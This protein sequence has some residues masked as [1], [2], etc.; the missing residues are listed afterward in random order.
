MAVSSMA[1][2][3]R[4]PAIEDELSVR[5]RADHVVHRCVD[6]PAVELAARLTRDRPGRG[7]IPDG[8]TVERG[9]P[10][11]RTG[12]R[13]RRRV[14]DIPEARDE[15]RVARGRHRDL[16]RDPDGRPA[17]GAG[18][19]GDRKGRRAD[20]LGVGE[21]HD[22]DPCRPAGR[23]MALGPPDERVATVGRRGGARVDELRLI[24][25]GQRGVALPVERPQRRWRERSPV[26]RGRI[27]RQLEPARA[28]AGP[29][30]ADARPAAARTGEDGGRT[31][32]RRD[33]HVPEGPVGQVD[34]AIAVSGMDHQP[35]RIR[36]R[37][38]DLEHRQA[39]R[40]RSRRGRRGRGRGRSGRRSHCR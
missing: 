11:V 33:R 37:S 28:R 3:V 23:A 17:G 30:A 18:R 7:Q 10:M 1:D 29:V 27:E 6:R 21:I 16:G 38:V 4:V 19:F 34:D 26:R 31:R 13:H 9:G 24:P 20:D 2:A 40:G 22:V 36:K 15:D 8:S 14:V 5:R 25:G 35:R 39:R 12:W 32:M